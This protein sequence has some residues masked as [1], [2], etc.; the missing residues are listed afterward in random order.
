MKEQFKS[1]QI[2]YYTLL[3]S[4]LFAGLFLMVL[5]PT[6]KE[7]GNNYMMLIIIGAITFSCLFLS[8]F[9]Y[10]KRMKQA[11]NLGDL[12]EKLFHYRSNSIY[13]WA[14]LE[15]PALWCVL[16]K[17]MLGNDLYLLLYGMAVVMLFLAR[18]T[19]E[20]FIKDFQLNSQEVIIFKSTMHKT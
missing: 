17:F 15:G 12:Q 10:N 6:Y 11:K 1:L 5:W 20:G 14:L 8:S 13:R 3:G 7:T 19:V 18:P 9:I 2:L 4:C 16:M